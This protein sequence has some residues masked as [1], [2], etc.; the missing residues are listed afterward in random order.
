MYIYN[1][2]Y[3]LYLL[4]Y[5]FIDLH[6]YISIHICVCI[7]I[8]IYIYDILVSK[9]TCIDMSFSSAEAA[10]RAAKPQ[11]SPLMS[12]D[13]GF[14]ASAGGPGAQRSQPPLG[15]PRKPQKTPVGPLK[16]PMGFPPPPVF[17]RGSRV[18]VGEM[19][20]KPRQKATSKLWSKMGE[21]EP[22]N[23]WSPP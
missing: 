2:V 18:L 1:P 17:S 10:V 6:I 19:L 9:H 16:Q 8:Y 21:S 5:L 7:Y 14:G 3:L 23:G 11:P 20:G 4:T 13:L 12:E 22:R 15:G